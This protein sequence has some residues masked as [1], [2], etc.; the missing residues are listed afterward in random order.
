[1]FKKWLLTTA[2][3]APP[4]EGGGE[5]DLE[6][7]GQENEGVQ[8]GQDPDEGLEGDVS[9]SDEGQDEDPDAEG[10]EGQVDPEPR[11]PS[12]AQ[13]RIQTLN[14]A[15]REAKERADRLERE[16]AE[17]RAETR[18]RQQQ[19]QQESPTDRA[20]RRALMDPMEAMREDLRESEQRTAALLQRT[21]MEAQEA[22]DKLNYNTLLRER[23]NLKKF[24][25]EVERVRLEQQ[26]KGMF[27][28]REVLLKLAVGDAALKAAERAAP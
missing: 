22:T 1:M 16:V 9:E 14:T 12:R 10:S 18:A 26:A 27:V 2:A 7:D 23:P 28:P 21:A 4:G 20:A 8:E 25:A 24:E 13:S 17:L 3:F 11:R 15:A 5:G 6:L 19:T